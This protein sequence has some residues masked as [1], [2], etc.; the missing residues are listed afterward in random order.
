M[1][2][3]DPISV[4]VRAPSRGLVT[5]FPRE[6]ADMYR[7]GDVQRTSTDA[8]NVRYEDGVT[9]NAPGYTQAQV[10][11][12]VT[13]LLAHWRMEE[14]SGNRIDS[15]INSYD[16]TEVTG[17]NADVVPSTVHINQTTGK[18]SKA[19]Q[20]FSTFVAGSYSSFPYLHTEAAPLVALA[21]GNFTITGWFNIGSVSHTSTLFSF[22]GVKLQ[23]VSG[24]HIQGTFF[25]STPT[26]GFVTNTFGGFIPVGSWFF[27]SLTYDGAQVTLSVNNTVSGSPYS[28][29]LGAAGPQTVTFF[30][31]AGTETVSEDS[32]SVFSRVLSG[33]ELTTI[34]NAGNGLDFPFNVGAYS[35]LYQGNLIGSVPTP[36]IG[37]HG[38]LVD[39]LDRSF[40]GGVF[41]LTPTNLFSGASP[42]TGYPWTATD[43]FD[44]IILAQHDNPAQY[45][46]APVPNVCQPVP[47]LPS[48]D[49]QWDGVEAFFGHV[50]LWKDDRLKWSDKDDFTNWIPVATTAASAV[51]IIDAPGFTQPAT[52]ATVAIPVTTDPV[53]A[54]IV[55]GQFIFIQDNRG[56]G[57]SNQFY[58]YYQVT[59]VGTGPNVITARLQDLTG[60]TTT[61]LTVAA[62]QTVFTVDAN[63]AGETRV[64]GSK[65]NGKIFKIIAMGDY[66]YIFK[67]RS[68]Q[69][70]QYVGL[71][72]GTFFI[73][74]ELSDEGALSLTAVL[75][76]GDGRI[77]FLGHKELYLYTG[78][79][80]PQPIATQVTRQVLKE[81]DRTRLHEIVMVHKEIRHEVWISYPIAGGQKTLIW[82][83]VEDTCSF[84]YYDSSVGGI[85]AASDVDFSVDP[86][87]NSLFESLTWDTMDPTLDWLSFAGASTDRILLLGFGDGE[88]VV[89]GYGNVFSR[90]GRGYKCLSETQDFDLGEPDI[91]KYVDVVVIGL[92]I[93]ASTNQTRTLYFQVGQRAGLGTSENSITFTDPFPVSVSGNTSDVV[94]IN[95]GGAGRYLRLRMFSQDPDV[96]WAVSSF[97]IHCRPGNTY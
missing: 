52:G 72:S 2:R 28:V 63:E 58:N 50:L 53:A 66:A 76:L 62:G 20:K 47:G 15:S 9:K 68:V 40:S 48:T 56:S 23:S 46:T 92:E 55:V 88:I 79:P 75:N 6:S 87:W 29:V 93:S 37:A 31:N 49:S 10:G 85:T 89:W 25:K 94:R 67:E 34:Y 81:I 83:Y 35:L 80:S 12:L 30:D 19:A 13:G 95:P 41:L 1:R 61:G 3:A 74:P 16:L 8:Q 18:L 54:G 39:S 7:Q 69:S 27:L 73:H 71:Q 26:A 38:G 17:D 42:T 43:F 84:D 44:T 96:E 57:T 5:R 36:L 60:H 24:G 11:S 91:W 97:E 82:N 51:F 45:W 21:S 77:V 78:G 59:A 70:V 4:R 14:A 33:T 65:M 90:N 86:P 22:P 32:V 64:V